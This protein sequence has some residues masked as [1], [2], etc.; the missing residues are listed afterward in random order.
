MLNVFCVIFYILIFFV[1]HLSKLSI[2]TRETNY[3]FH[4]LRTVKVTPDKPIV[5]QG[6]SGFVA[7][8][9]MQP[10]ITGRWLISTSFRPPENHCA[11][12]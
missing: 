1:V 12:G 11:V 7:P 4:C 9:H 5:A 2:C 6:G 10:V 8:I 3:V